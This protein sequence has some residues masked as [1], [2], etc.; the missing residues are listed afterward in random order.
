LS[1]VVVLL[2]RNVLLE[3]DDGTGNGYSGS[4]SSRAKISFDPKNPT[5][6]AVTE[7]RGKDRHF[8]I[9]AASKY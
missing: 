1:L 4:R 8:L 3:R 7:K 5:I 9:F 2:H 6:L